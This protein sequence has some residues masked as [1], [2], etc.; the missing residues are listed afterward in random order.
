ML[1]EARRATIYRA[2]T[3]C[4]ALLRAPCRCQLTH[5][6]GPQLSGQARSRPR[7]LQPGA[8][9]TSPRLSASAS[10]IKRLGRAAS[11]LTA[12]SSECC[13]RAQPRADSVPTYLAQGGTRGEHVSTAC[14]ANDER[15]CSRFLRN[16][17]EISRETEHLPQLAGAGSHP[18]SLS[19][20]LLLLCSAPP[21]SLLPPEAQAS[22]LVC[23]ISKG[24]PALS[25]RQKG[26]PV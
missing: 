3:V 15:R 16:P 4:Q 7:P 25:W 1:K 5:S 6:I 13:L 20:A 23:V 17:F 10:S 26:T 11:P 9:R 12:P 19:G 24:L 8:R 14:A 18:P 21:T 2:L 22:S